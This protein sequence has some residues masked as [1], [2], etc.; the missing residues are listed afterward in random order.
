MTDMAETGVAA[1]ELKQFVERIERLEEEI[2]ALNEDKR[3]VYAEAKGRGFDVA[4]LK[5]V[6]RLRAKDPH[7]RIEQEA[8]LDLYLSALGMLPPDH[9]A[10]VAPPRAHAHERA[11][12]RPGEITI[13]V[14]GSSASMMP[15]DAERILAAAHTEAGRSVLSAAIAVVREADPVVS[16]LGW[17]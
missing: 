7:E 2:R 10:D 6:V 16:E 13:A 8:M 12:A 4:T 17:A 11:A 14:G 15:K 9:G 1:E 3:D 5:Q